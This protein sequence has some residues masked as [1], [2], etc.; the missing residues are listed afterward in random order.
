M[1]RTT[2]PPAYRLYKRT[3]QAVVTLNGHDH[4]L[5]KHG[6][7]TSRNAYDRLVGEW[8]QHGRTLPGS[9]SETEGVSVSELIAAYWRHAKSYYVKN[10]QPTSEH[11]SIKQAMKPLRRLYGREPARDFGPLALKTVRQSMVDLDWSRGYINDQIDRIRRMFRWAVESELVPPIV[12]HGLRA[13]PGLRRGRSKVRETEPVKPIPEVHIEAVRPHVNARVWGLI[14]IQVLTGCRPGEAV[15][16]RGCDLDVSGRIWAYRPSSHKT[17]HHGKERIIYL[18]PRAQQVVRQFLTTDLNAYLFS[19]AKAEATR[20][21]EMRAHRKTPMTPIHRARAEAARSRR[22][23]R[24]PRDHYDVASYRRAITRAC[25]Q[26]DLAAK[27]AK[28][29]LPDSE[30]LLPRWHPHQLRHTAA[31]RLRKEFGIESAR[32]IL[33]HSS[34]TMTDLYAELDTAKAQD[35]MSKIG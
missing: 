18:G 3:G 21:R 24:A 12:C 25:D 10:G 33:G 17:E 14:Q 11:G 27:K 22:R 5:G 13:V 32:V 7:I 20:K 29:V 26:A 16:M 19:P 2:K 28:E 6:T 31:T 1:P 4:Y 30:R 8:L 35:V 34:P 15:A 9:R 23:Q